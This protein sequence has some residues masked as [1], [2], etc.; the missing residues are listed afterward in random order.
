M[1]VTW[2]ADGEISRTAVSG[3]DPTYREEIDRGK[4]RAM[5]IYGLS[6]LTGLIALILLRK[7]I[8]LYRASRSHLRRV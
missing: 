2:I 4:R 6:V 3:D 8:R 5:P 1:R 7:S